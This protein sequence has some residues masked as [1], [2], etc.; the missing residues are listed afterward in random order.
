MGQVE[1]YTMAISLS[2][3]QMEALNGTTFGAVDTIPRAPVPGFANFDQATTVTS[4]HADLKQVVVTT[5]W[6]V[7]NG[8]NSASLTTYIVNA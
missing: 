3:E 8:E 5:Y 1:N 6:A 4:V 2:Q 7:P